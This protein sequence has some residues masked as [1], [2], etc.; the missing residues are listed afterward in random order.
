[1]KSTAEPEEPLETAATDDGLDTGSEIAIGGD[2]AEALLASILP[3]IA[4]DDYIPGR[5]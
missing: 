4:I 1:M 2:E 3:T 5:S